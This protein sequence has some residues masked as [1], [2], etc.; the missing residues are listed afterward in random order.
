MPEPQT[1]D[2]M[3]Q[4]ASHLGPAISRR[5]SL[6]S[7][8]AEDSEIERRIR[9]GV[10]LA[11]ATPWILIFAI[12]IASIGLNVNSTAV[13]IGAMLISPLMGPIVGAGLG[14]A[15]YDFALVKR[16]LL[17]LAI[18]TSISLAVSTLYFLLSP[19]QDAQSEL[20][21]R[22]TPTIW[23]VL[24]ALFGGLAGIVGISRRE[25]STVIPGV[26]I[27]TALMPPVCTAGFGIATGNW[28]FVF[29]AL[30]LF[31]INSVFIALA[32]AIGVRLLRLRRHTFADARAR[33]KV[34]LSLLAIALVTAVPSVY[35]A[36]HLVREEMYKANARKF[37]AQ[38]FA[39]KDT[40]VA[41][42]RINYQTRTLEVALVGQIIPETELRSI[43]SRLP[44]R[45]LSGSKI[46]V[47]QSGGT[48]PDIAGL[49]STIS[50][51]LY[52][53][54]QQDLQRRDEKIKQLQRELDARNAVFLS[55][56]D[57]SAELRAQYPSVSSVSIG[58]AV[59]V[60][61]DATKKPL[62]LLSVKSTKPLSTEERLRIENWFKVR[63]KADAVSLS[64]ST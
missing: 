18:A 62:V 23:D 40:Q 36:T 27:A 26:A 7:D 57:I 31:A 45:K 6:H 14:V 34:K 3:T 53:E 33:W 39:L 51:D 9:D 41:D 2:A 17:N 4:P 52:I 46:V 47:R 37:I 22:T 59:E 20:L 32:T 38:E 13:I 54:S 50:R 15:T 25:K 48:L 8:K 21:A 61:A 58:D 55:A 60:R 30:Y 12:F 19:L 1:A 49:K 10:D 16:A 11:G 29:G 43:E 64:F 56:E 42:S 28:S 44:A 35:L 63:T 24:I 5:F